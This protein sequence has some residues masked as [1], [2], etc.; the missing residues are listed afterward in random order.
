MYAAVMRVVERQ[1]DRILGPMVQQRAQYLQQPPP[2]AGHPP[3][4]HGPQSVD[5]G[6]AP[7]QRST[8]PSLP[9][10][11]STVEGMSVSLAD[12]ARLMSQNEGL[13]VKLAEYEHANKAR[14]AKQKERKLRAA[15]TKKRAIV[16]DS[17]DSAATSSGAGTSAAGP[18]S[19]YRDAIT[20]SS[21]APV[22]LPD[23]AVLDAILN[24]NRSVSAIRAAVVAL[25]PGRV[26]KAADI[27][28]ACFPS[29]DMPSSK[30]VALKE[31]AEFLMKNIG[32]LSVAKK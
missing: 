15:E 25:R 16:I 7:P 24:A 23:E 17:T 14:T 26:D 13:K 1:A 11:P 21:I 18:P 27:W 32:R 28:R 22:Q 4:R 5:P 31:L 2:P 9:T 3:P 19:P 6:S 30:D 29:A 20:K 10:V 8:T 12:Y